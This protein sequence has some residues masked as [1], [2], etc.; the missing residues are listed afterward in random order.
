MRTDAGTR[1]LTSELGAARSGL[2]ALGRRPL[3]LRSQGARPPTRDAGRLLALGHRCTLPARRGE[4]PPTR[5][6]INGVG[7]PEQGW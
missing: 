7:G 4:A 1:A 2:L 3:E 5:R 6:R